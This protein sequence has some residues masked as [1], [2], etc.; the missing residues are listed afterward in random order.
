MAVAV[1]G[2]LASWMNGTGIAQ[3]RN[4]LLQPPANPAGGGVHPLAGPIRS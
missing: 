1:T 2:G 4:A 3:V